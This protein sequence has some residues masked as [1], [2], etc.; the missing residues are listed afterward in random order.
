MNQTERLQKIFEL[1]A[2]KMELENRLENIQVDIKKALDELITNEHGNISE[3]VKL[4]A[5]AFHYTFKE[6]ETSMGE[7][8][9][10]N[11]SGG[12][13][14]MHYRGY[15]YAK[16]Q[17]KPQLLQANTS[18]E[19]I[20]RLQNWNKAR[21]DN[22]Q[23]TIVN[24]GSLDNSQNKYT[25]YH[26][27]EVST[28]KDITSIYL[29]IPP[30]EKEEFLKTV[31]YLKENGA[32]YLP[33]QRRW[34]ITADMNKEPFEQFLPKENENSNVSVAQPENTKEYSL[35]LS[36]NVEA[37]ECMVAFHDGREPITLHGDKFGVNFAL[38]KTPDE[39]AQVVEDFIK[40]QMTEVKE[41]ILDLNKILPGS[42]I[43]CY[44][45]NYFD[46]GTII[47]MQKLEATVNS[48]LENG[49]VLFDVCSINEYAF[50]ANKDIL[51]S[52]SQADVIDRAIQSQLSP[53]MINMMTCSVYSPGQMDVM[54]SAAKDGFMTHE[55]SRFRDLAA[56]DMDMMRIGLQ[57]GVEAKAIQGICEKD[58]PWADKRKLLN[59]EIRKAED[60]IGEMFRRDGYPINRETARKVIK[61]NH[62]TKQ[63]NTTQNVSDAFKNQ[64]YKESHPEK[65]KLVNDISKECQILAMKQ[66]QMCM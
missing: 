46:D 17:Q 11:S 43:E 60:K 56:P 35:L 38:I 18:E 36:K 66:P 31:Q 45:P 48:V 40:Q 22:M 19:I 12:Q 50:G 58:L 57:N 54:L 13:E 52:K 37:N 47:G 8:F 49:T 2:Q 39:I 61:L 65:Q 5:D 44:V 53:E 14:H 30:Q 55:I 10:Q 1:D 41:E 27:Y 29:N 34:Y 23:Y 7:D 32:K 16:G 15:A 63:K 51:F 62:L 6:K 59:G 64:T 4:V 33:Q 24:I 20:L 3:D 21:P 25:N 9:K 42:K 26:K 28:G